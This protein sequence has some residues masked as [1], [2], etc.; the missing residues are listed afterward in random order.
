MASS[1]GRTSKRVVAAGAISLAVYVILNHGIAWHAPEMRRAFAITRQ[2]A[3]L[4]KARRAALGIPADP[5]ADPNGTGLVG[6]EYSDLMTSAG[7][8]E[9]KR[10]TTNPDFAAL[11]V[12]LLCE[13]GVSREDR[14]AI[15]SSGS[16]PALMI[17]SLAAVKAMEARPVLLLSLGASSY[18]ATSP[19]LN[20]LDIH[21]ILRDAGICDIPP[22]GVSLGGDRDLGLDFE[23]DLRDRLA[24]R[25]QSA[26]I[27]FLHEPD[28]VKNVSRRVEI[29][30]GNAKR[31]IAAFVNC[32][33]SYASMGT[34]P[35]ALELR[36]GLNR[37]I[38][39]LPERSQ[40]GV[41]FEMAARGVPVIHLLHIRGLAQQYGLRWDPQPLPDE[42]ELAL[43]GRPTAPFWIVSIG[44][45]AL[46]VL[47]FRK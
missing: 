20:L 11:I 17:A 21:D 33:G 4:V 43:P 30:E 41:M 42:P 46:L 6:P 16:F 45:F 13:A 12:H 36:P 3:E 8:L 18:G 27:P 44:Y 39:A 26:G 14:V 34:S 9:A 23:P 10:T 38:E 29:Y 2:A 32:G 35:L 25:I 5:G 37:K 40:R 22:A 15:A 1:A 7:D 47:L 31:P 19:R 24:R 28:L